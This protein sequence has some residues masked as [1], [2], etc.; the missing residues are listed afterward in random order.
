MTSLVV[1][2]SGVYVSNLETGSAWRSTSCQVVDRPYELASS[3]VLM[4]LPER[5]SD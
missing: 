5:P 1:V 3:R 2:E 4:S